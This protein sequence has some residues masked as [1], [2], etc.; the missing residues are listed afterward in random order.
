MPLQC[1]GDRIFPPLKG[2]A[3]VA[4]G[5]EE[6]PPP[7]VNEIDRFTKTRSGWHVFRTNRNSAAIFRSIYPICLIIFMKTAGPGRA[8]GGGPSFQEALESSSLKLRLSSLA[9]HPLLAKFPGM[10]LPGQ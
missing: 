10:S 3:N 1:L 4:E 8:R 7:S 6:A 2:E 5:T 9:E